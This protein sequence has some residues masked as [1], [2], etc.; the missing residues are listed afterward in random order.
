MPQ[1]LQAIRIDCHWGDIPRTTVR[2]GLIFGAFL[3][4][5]AVLAAN[6]A[7]QYSSSHRGFVAGICKQWLYFHRKFLPDFLG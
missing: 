3:A 1:V 4:P 7:L 5:E 2:H 6:G